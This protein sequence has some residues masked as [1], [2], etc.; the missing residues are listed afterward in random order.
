M[1]GSSH[2]C[3]VALNCGHSWCKSCARENIR[4]GLGDAE[5]WPPKCCEPFSEQVIGWARDQHW[6]QLWRQM[7]EEQGTPGGQRVYCSR[8]DCAEFI[9]NRPGRWLMANGERIE[10]ADQCLACGDKTCRKCRHPAHPGKKCH[11][12]QEDE[13]LMDLMDRERMAACPECNR[14]IQLKEGCN[15]IT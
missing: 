15:H 4:V 6:V 2:V 14:V 11:L 3:L 12:D 9:P 7:G 1:C 13:E 5:S 10:E 8:P